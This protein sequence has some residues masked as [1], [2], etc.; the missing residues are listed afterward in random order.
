MAST[1]GVS[2]LFRRPEAAGRGRGRR[3]VGAVL[4][5]IPDRHA[6]FIAV[7]LLGAVVMPHNF[8]CTPPSCFQGRSRWASDRCGRRS[9]TTSRSRRRVGGDP[10]HQ[11]G[12]SSSPRGRFATP[13]SWI[14]PVSDARHHRTTAAERAG[15]AEKCLGT[16]AKVSSPPHCSPLGRL[17]HHGRTPAVR[18]GGVPGDSDQPG[19]ASVPDALGRHHL[20]PGHNHRRESTPSIS[21]S[22][23]P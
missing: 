12:G 9:S 4:P 1:M 11:L 20:P 22:S 10:L 21:S 23:P 17:D 3:G 13:T 2:H 19:V 8:S 15:D 7:S 16:A 5:V 14:P 6:L 18:H